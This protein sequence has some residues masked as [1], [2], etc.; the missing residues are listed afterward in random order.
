MP[1]D[2]EIVLHRESLSF[3]KQRVQDRIEELEI[4]LSQGDPV[5]NRVEPIF[6]EFALMKRH[7]EEIEDLRAELDAIEDVMAMEGLLDLQRGT[8]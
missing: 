6:Q 5:G 1:F 3:R 8:A 2:E 4:M 7:I